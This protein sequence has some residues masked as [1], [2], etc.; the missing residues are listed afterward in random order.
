MPYWN[1]SYFHDFVF[2]SLSVVFVFHDKS[3]MRNIKNTA[4]K[5]ATPTPDN[6]DSLPERKQLLLCIL[7]WGGMWVLVG[8]GRRWQ[9]MFSNSGQSQSGLI[10]LSQRWLWCSLIR[11]CNQLKLTAHPPLPM[12]NWS[13]FWEAT[14]FAFCILKAASHTAWCSSLGNGELM[15]KSHHDQL[16]I[17]NFLQ[18]CVFNILNLVFYENHF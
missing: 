14:Y 3:Q 10:H 11:K 15:V 4:W 13:G 8:G 16:C 18:V 9:R 1:D 2:V 5:S 6:R 12:V 17:L 7:V